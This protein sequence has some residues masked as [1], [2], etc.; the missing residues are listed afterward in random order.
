MT[1]LLEKMNE[2]ESFGYS[3]LEVEEYK[4]NK[5]EE[6][7]SFGYSDEDIYKELNAVHPNTYNNDT[8][9][10]EQNKSFW[11]NVKEKAGAVKER[12]IGEDF[13]ISMKRALGASLYNIGLQQADKGIPLEEAFEVDEDRGF[14]EQGIE[15]IITLAAD[16]PFYGA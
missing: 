1:S 16:L 7:K 15:S 5:I 12:A 13:D 9:V 6:Y 2:M 8:V 14:L 3:P 4:N 11:Q 10:K